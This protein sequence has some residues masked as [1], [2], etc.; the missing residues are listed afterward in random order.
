METVQVSEPG[1]SSILTLV[2]KQ[3]IDRNL[4]DP[5]K[6]R[7]I[8]GRCFK[9]VFNAGRMYTTLNFDKKTINA[10]E[11]KTEEADFSVSGDIRTFVELGTGASPLLP[12]IKRKIRFCFKGWRGFIVG[13]RIIG[14]LRPGKLP[15]YLRW[16]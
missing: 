1:K 2:L 8:Q 16:L 4:K 11:G 3:I 12:L 15:F 6:R 7:I 10:M 5:R 13:L 9:V 14:L